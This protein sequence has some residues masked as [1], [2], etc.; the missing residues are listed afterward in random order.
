MSLPLI[1]KGLCSFIARCRVLILRW[2][3]S[4]MGTIGTRCRVSRVRMGKVVRQLQALLPR[5]ALL[6]LAKTRQVTVM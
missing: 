4:A 3:P 2:A 5:R 1:T 6:R